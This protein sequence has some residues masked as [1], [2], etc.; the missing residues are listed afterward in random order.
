[1]FSLIATWVAAVGG[2]GT[3]LGLVVWALKAYTAA[4]A[5]KA[6]ADERQAG[7]D[8]RDVEATNAEIKRMQDAAAAGAAAGRVYDTTADPND[9]QGK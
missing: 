6:I 1:M 3:V 5:D 8:A 4:K 2:L 9:K 7:A